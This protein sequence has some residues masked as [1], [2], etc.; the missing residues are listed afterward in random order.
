MAEATRS[1]RVELLLSDIEAAVQQTR[2][3][4]VLTGALWV[5]VSEQF[6]SS[7]LQMPSI[8]PRKLK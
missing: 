5:L 7:G 2:G 4:E 8:A 6:V 1:A 3:P